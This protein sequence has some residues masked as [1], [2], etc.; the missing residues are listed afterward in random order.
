MGAAALGDAMRAGEVS[1]REIIDAHLDVIAARDGVVAEGDV[2]QALP[3]DR[4]GPDDV[5]AFLVVTA[6]RARS[7]ADDVDRRRRAEP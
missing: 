7:H 5:H 6:A 4:L 1:A 3:A 2:W